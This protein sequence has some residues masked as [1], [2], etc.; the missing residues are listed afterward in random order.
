LVTALTVLVGLDIQKEAN[1]FVFSDN[2]LF[3]DNYNAFDD[4]WD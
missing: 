3:G 4:D 1:L 2:E